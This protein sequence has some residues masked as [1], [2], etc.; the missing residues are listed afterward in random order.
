[1][2]N[3]DECEQTTGNRR[4]AKGRNPIFEHAGSA[5][6]RC[7]DDGNLGVEIARRIHTSI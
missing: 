6:D 1:M 7:G 5:F 2:E 3:I 4:G